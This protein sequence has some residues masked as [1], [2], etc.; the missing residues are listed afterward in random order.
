MNSTRRALL[1]AALAL[2]ALRFARAQDAAP[3]PIL[4]VH[5][6]G[7]HAALWMTT[8]WRFES[9]GIAR[10]RLLAVNMPDPLARANDAVPQPNRSSAAEQTERLAFFVRDLRARTGAPRV[11]L[12]GNSRGGY[13]IR[14]FVV[15][16]GGAPEVSHAV[17]C[18]TPNRGVYDWEWNEGSEFNGRA[19]FLRRLN[20]GASDV[21][22]G[23]AFLT[24]RSDNDLY[25]QP[26]GRFVGRPGTPTGVDQDGPM[27]RGA[28]NILLPGLDHREV[29][30]HWRAFREYFRFIAGREAQA[31]DVTPEA[32]PVLNGIVTGLASGAP[33]NRPVTGARVEVFRV[34]P[35]TGART[36]EAIHAR[37]TGADGV[38]GPV[39]VEPGWSLEIVLA[40]PGHPIAHFFRSPFPR[41]TE[42]L[43]LRPPAPLAEADRGAGALVR[44]TRPRG[45]FSWPRDVGLLD[46]REV[47]ER[48]EGVA[49]VATA[50][51]R[52]PADRTGTP[53]RSVFNTESITA[54]AVPLAE[55][56]IAFAEMTW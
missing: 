43:H 56:R 13:P 30:Y 48:R 42:V 23:T 4:L 9:N 51:L 54:R 10:D 22:E 11:A 35:A 55:N 12:V 17:T 5:G 37:E 50:T 32:R 25:A 33:T 53:V 31:F 38:W 40:V 7:D 39:T 52:L 1:G 19:P 41:G 16:A 36:G 20:G 49:S 6:N 27:L 47:A 28:T 3:P 18:G 44:L 46:G 45:Y 8:L 14:D 29:A 24:L 34:D 15:H 26:D 2:P 21:V